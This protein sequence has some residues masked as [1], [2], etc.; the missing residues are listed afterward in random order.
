MQAGYA[1]DIISWEAHIAELSQSKKGL[2]DVQ[3]V[4]HCYLSTKPVIPTQFY[5][6]FSPLPIQTLSVLVW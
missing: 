4:V 2:Y 3:N 5:Y 6:S 1:F